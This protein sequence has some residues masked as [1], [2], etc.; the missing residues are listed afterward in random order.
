MVMMWYKYLRGK[1]GESRLRSIIKELVKTLNSLPTLHKTLL[2]AIV[3][4]NITILIIVYLLKSK[5]RG[6]NF[7]T[8]IIAYEKRNEKLFNFGYN[9]LYINSTWNFYHF[10]RWEIYGRKRKAYCYFCQFKFFSKS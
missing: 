4:N 9:N 1:V 2:L 6:S 8:S 7:P 10:I 3:I 5:Y